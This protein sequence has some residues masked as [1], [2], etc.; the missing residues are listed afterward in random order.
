[1]AILVIYWVYEE[2]NGVNSVELD[3][4]SIPKQTNN[5]EIFILALGLNTPWFISNVGILSTDN[6]VKEFHLRLAFKQGSKFEE[7][8]GGIRS[9]H[10]TQ[11]KAWRHEM[12]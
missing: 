5:A 11:T 3:T 10:D 2:L 1:M 4:P 7:E 9:V 12:A 8:W 6:S